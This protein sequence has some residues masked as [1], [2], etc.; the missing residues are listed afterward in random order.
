[1]R[2]LIYSVIELRV[3][4]GRTNAGVM[5]TDDRNLVW[6]LCYL[7]LDQLWQSYPIG[8]GRCCPIKLLRDPSDVDSVATASPEFST[9]NTGVVTS[10]SGLDQQVSS[11]G[12]IH[13]SASCLR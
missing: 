5:I 8:K 2:K 1:M 9:V 3:C 11:P 10:T 6:I 4:E 12:E 7:D 13:G